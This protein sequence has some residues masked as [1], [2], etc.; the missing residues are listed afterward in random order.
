[1]KRGALLLGT[2]A[3]SPVV[4]VTVIGGHTRMPRGSPFVRKGPIR[5]VFSKPVR[6]AG[7][8]DVASAELAART[9]HE[10]QSTK[11]HLALPPSP[12]PAGTRRRASARTAPR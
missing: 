8:D 1:M 7:N 5:V 12:A 10:F 11:R 6:I 3:C 2:S 4:C 9:V